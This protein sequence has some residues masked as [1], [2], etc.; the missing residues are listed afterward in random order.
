MIR[1]TIPSAALLLSVLL[2]AQ[3]GTVISGRLLGCDGRPMRK[4]QAHVIIPWEPFDRMILSTADAASDGKY[5]LTFDRAGLFM[6]YLTGVDHLNLQFPVIV[7]KP[8]TLSV[9]AR[10]HSLS[11]PSGLEKVGIIGDF[12][13]FSK[14]ASVNMEKLPDGTFSAM[15]ETKA[16]MFAY[17]VIG[18]FGPSGSIM[19]VNGTQSDDEVF[20]TKYYSSYKSII[21]TPDSGK[22]R[23]VFDPRNMRR[24]SSEAELSIEGDPIM[25][26]FARISMDVE[27][28]IEMMRLAKIDEE[29]SGR[30]RPG[31][32][33]EWARDVGE[34]KAH[35]FLEKAPLL[36][37]AVLLG[38][39]RLAQEAG[40]PLDPDIC[41][42]AFD[43]IPPTSPLWALDPWVLHPAGDAAGRP[44]DYETYLENVLGRN[45]D[46]NLKSAVIYGEL[47]ADKEP[48]RARRLL[49]RLVREYP[50]SR[51][52]ES[53]ELA[54]SPDKKILIGKKIPSFSIPSLADQNVLIAAK[55]L[56]GKFVL[57]D[58]W[59]TW[60]VACINEMENIHKAYAKFKKRNFEILSLSLDVKSQNIDLFRRNKWPMPWLHAF[61]EGGSENPIARTFEVD[62]LPRA[63]LVDPQRT[64]VA[65]DDELRGPRLDETLKRFLDE[66]GA[67]QSDRTIRGPRGG[68]ATPPG[69][70]R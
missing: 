11:V 14:F 40:L 24:C 26:R 42:K 50:H 27:R 45:P 68:K 52:T 44:G 53:A 2:P 21:R 56:E 23:I 67:A 65:L 35:M 70:P 4:A 64:I 28:S 41:R 43:E 55:S 60:C 49:D 62:S 30:A 12:N 39:L 63:I 10:L 59:A 46:P 38:Y 51:F 8:L 36:R 32:R 34:M 48:G 22:V 57:I 20:D 25:E 19:A 16:P 7:D 3:D 33:Q 5:R 61:I 13:A 18:P 15:F 17:Q 54:L 1:A 66:H 6:V 31:V 47:V 29:R 69:N 37:Q 9:S 58:F